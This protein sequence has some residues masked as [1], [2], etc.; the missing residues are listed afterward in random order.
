MPVPDTI[1][2]KQMKTLDISSIFLTFGGNELPSS[3]SSTMKRIIYTLFLALTLQTLLAQDAQF[4]QFNASP[5]EINPALSG[6]YNGSFKA[7]LN[8]RS[9]WGS[10]LG[11]DAFKTMA[12]SY[13]MRVKGLGRGD[14][15]SFSINA[16]RDEAGTA[17][18]SLTKG[19]LGMAY[20]KKLWDGRYGKTPQ[21][22]IV[23]AQAGLGQYSLNAGD[24]W[25]SSQYDPGTV[26]VD[27]TASNNEPWVAN[28]TPFLNFNVGGL[29][30][31]IFGE[32]FSIYTGL[33]MQHINQPNISLY[34]DQVPLAR[35]Y[36]ASIGGQ[37]PITR[38][39]SVLPGIVGIR[40]GPS[41]QSVFGGHLRYSNKD[42]WEIAL[43]AGIFAR[44]ANKLDEGIHNDAI[45]YSTTFD[46][47]R[48]SMGISYDMNVSSLQASTN[49]RGA[50][51]LSLSYTQPTTTRRKHIECPKF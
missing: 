25:F 51:E 29:W 31:A 24:L 40:Q 13:D 19:N 48:W 23:G 22:M 39:I 38:E 43:R 2:N 41:F 21:Y 28:G 35:K 50:F 12:A 18:I 20:H 36:T 27:H 33:A 1:I 9:Q 5:L 11:S 16:L 45:I 3:K 42:W 44:I 32:D 37:I 30:Y 4:S 15:F 26:S 47:E 6:V 7:N 17:K 14:Y 49:R 46:I 8:Y 10:I 34:E